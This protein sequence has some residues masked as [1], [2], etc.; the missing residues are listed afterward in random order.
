MWGSI[1]TGKGRKEYD[2][3]YRDLKE[4]SAKALRELFSTDN[5]IIFIVILPSF[6]KLGPLKLTST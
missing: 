5:D 6:Q 1:N 4:E 2:R 3:K